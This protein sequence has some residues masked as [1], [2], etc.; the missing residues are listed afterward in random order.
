MV[1]LGHLTAWLLHLQHGD[2]VPGLLHTDIVVL[3]PGYGHVQGPAGAAR[4]HRPS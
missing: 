3:Q 4:G 1:F 2:H